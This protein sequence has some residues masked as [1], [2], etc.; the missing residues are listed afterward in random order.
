MHDGDAMMACIADRTPA[1]RTHSAHRTVDGQTSTVPHASCG[2]ASPQHVSDVSCL[3]FRFA[4]K[5]FQSK[6]METG[7]RSEA[8]PPASADRP[9]SS[10]EQPQQTTS[11][12]EDPTASHGESQAAQQQQQEQPPD[13]E[14]GDAMEDINTYCANDESP[15]INPYCYWW[16]LGRIRQVGR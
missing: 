9:P 6:T 15:R 12:G 11:S 3:R 5:D 10:R 16:W 14:R 1:P 4:A 7:G 8:E 13:M 2:A